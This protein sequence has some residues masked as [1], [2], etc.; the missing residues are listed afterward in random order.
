VTA[1]HTYITVICIYRVSLTRAFTL[2][3]YALRKMQVILRAVSLT[4]TN[5]ELEDRLPNSGQKTYNSERY[6][7]MAGE[8]N[9]IGIVR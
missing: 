6:V 2:K 9:S 1:L 3:L 7:G 8:E 5:L 4:S